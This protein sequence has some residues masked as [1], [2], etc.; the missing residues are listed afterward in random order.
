MESNRFVW[1]NGLQVLFVFQRLGKEGMTRCICVR[2]YV[3][4]IA[5]I[6][7]YYLR[8]VET[9]VADCAL[10][11]FS[12]LLCCII[13][14]TSAQQSTLE[15][16]DCTRIVL[17]S[18]MLLLELDSDLNLRSIT[19]E[20]IHCATMMETLKIHWTGVTKTAVKDE[21]TLT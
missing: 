5:L 12:Q 9:F 14:S 6:K 10:L 11:C 15:T 13:T 1:T 17:G 2:M 21:G 4:I 3:C 20:K 8:D 19:K 18:V 16:Q 7:Y